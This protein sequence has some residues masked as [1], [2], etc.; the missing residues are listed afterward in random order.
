[1]KR[2]AF[3]DSRRTRTLRPVAPTTLGGHVHK[4]RIEAGL[5]QGQLAAVFGVWRATLGA[6]EA[7]HYEPT[8]KVRDRVVAWLGFDPDEKAS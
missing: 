1:V 2:A 6:W 4:N 3:D 5:T 7:G 8:G